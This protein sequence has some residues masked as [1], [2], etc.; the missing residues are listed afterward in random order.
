LEA[1]ARAVEN[2]PDLILDLILMDIRM[3]VMDGLEATM[4]ILA[5]PELAS[6]PIVGSLVLG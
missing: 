3:P 1:V 4:R 2:K 6:T 5:I